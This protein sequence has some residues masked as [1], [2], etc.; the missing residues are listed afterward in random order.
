MSAPRTHTITVTSNGAAPFTYTDT[1]DNGKP[2]QPSTDHH[3]NHKDKICWTSSSGPISVTFQ[4]CCNPT[5]Q[6]PPFTAAANVNTQTVT[7]IGH[8]PEPPGT[9]YKYFVVV[10]N[11]LDDPQIIF[12][13]S[14]ML[15]IKSAKKK[16][17]R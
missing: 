11:V 3:V 1:I 8:I 4:P 9:A 10:N 2:G 12:D 16:K 5:D 14:G 15:I 7:L 6:L 17:K 13:D